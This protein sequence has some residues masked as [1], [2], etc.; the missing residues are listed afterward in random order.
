MCCTFN[1]HIYSE[2]RW[3]RYIYITYLH[4][5][6]QC[7]LP[8]ARY[9]G[10][11]SECVEYTCV[12]GR[13]CRFLSVVSGPKVSSSTVTFSPSQ[14]LLCLTTMVW[15]SSSADDTRP[16]SVGCMWAGSRV[17]GSGWEMAADTGVT[18]PKG[19]EES[20]RDGENTGRVMEDNR[21]RRQLR[22]VAPASLM[23]PC[24]DFLNFSPLH[25]TL[26][27]AAHT[28]FVFSFSLSLP[29]CAAR[30]S[31]LFALDNAVRSPLSLCDGG[32]TCGLGQWSDGSVQQRNTHTS[33]PLLL[34]FTAPEHHSDYLFITCMSAFKNL[35]AEL[36][37]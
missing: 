1:L 37:I 35:T 24:S 16:S 17:T 28:S 12:H 20:H 36:L 14:D 9:F 11:V 5:F 3:C 18:E 29:F 6:G 10:C 4:T 31:A 26:P 2:S 21:R 13:C 32:M 15:G 34:S 23:L 33:F 22:W 19:H 27:S 7:Q 30:S 8:A 25:L